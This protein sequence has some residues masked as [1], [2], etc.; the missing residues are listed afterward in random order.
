MSKQPI[1]TIFT[2]VGPQHA[3]H[4]SGFSVSI[5]DREHVGYGDPSTNATIE[6]DFLCGKVP[7]YLKSLAIKVD[8]SRSGLQTDKE[9]ILKRMIEGLRFLGVNF[10]ILDE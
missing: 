7:L 8:K 3:L 4:E 6:A 9:T 10:E 5:F 1:E 2:K